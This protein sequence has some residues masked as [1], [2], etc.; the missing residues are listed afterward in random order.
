METAFLLQVD[1]VL[2]PLHFLKMQRVYCLHLSLLHTHFRAQLFVWLSFYIS[3]AFKQSTNTNMFFWMLFI[4]LFFIVE[5]YLIAW[6][7]GGW[8]EKG[9]KV[10]ME[11]WLVLTMAQDKNRNSDA[12]SSNFP[13]MGKEIQFQSLWSKNTAATSTPNA[14]FCCRVKKLFST[15][16]ATSL[17]VEDEQLWGRGLVT[18]TIE[19]L[20]HMSA[21]TK[22]VLRSELAGR[23]FIHDL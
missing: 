20:C 4:G 22:R 6:L 18:V 17:G 12:L 14:P 5:S 2:Y 10:K 9:G 21:H 3:R 15:F 16:K 11:E 23:E 7:D 1:G 13:Y 8:G 19:H